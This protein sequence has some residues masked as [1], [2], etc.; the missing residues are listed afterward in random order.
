MKFL[1]IE[2]EHVFAYDNR[3]FVNLSGTTD[4]RNI[5]LVWG[6]NGSGKTSF[7]NALKLLFTGVEHPSSRMVGFPPRPLAPRQYVVGD[8]AGWSGLINQPA[9]RRA[10]RDGV[11]VVARVKAAWESGG[12]TVSAERQWTYDGATF[13]ESL[14]VFDGEERLAMDAAEARLE[15]F[16]PKDFVGFFFFDGEDIKSLA[17]SAERK[18]IDFDKLLRIAFLNEATTELRK[19]I[20]ERPTGKEAGQDLRRPPRGRG[21]TD[22]DSRR[23]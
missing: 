2:I 20:T 15:D 5:I 6:R 1:S 11:P 10:E 13:K 17:E 18:Q 22:E 16:L 21:R 3:A 4:D 19:L 14:R 7:L 23:H 8:G 9:R 12:L